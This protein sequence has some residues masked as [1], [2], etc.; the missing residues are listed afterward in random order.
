VSSGETPLQLGDARL[1]P[2]GRVVQ[3]HDPK[4]AGSNPAG[5]YSEKIARKAPFSC[6]LEARRSSQAARDRV[7]TDSAEHCGLGPAASFAVIKSAAR[8]RSEP[9]TG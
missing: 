8:A 9:E 6:C 1:Q 3:T 5:A 7:V 2:P 4:R